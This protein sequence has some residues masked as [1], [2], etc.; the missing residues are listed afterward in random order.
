V[1]ACF[2]P[3][4]PNL[5]LAVACFDICAGSTATADPAVERL[6][7]AEA[8]AKADECRAMA[9]IEPIQ[10]HRVMLISIAETWERIAADTKWK[11]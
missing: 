4:R 1:L 9:T 5:K 6:N 7:P 11:Q 10:S 2:D 3:Q 8:Q